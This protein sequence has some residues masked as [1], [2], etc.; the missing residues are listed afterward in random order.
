M[1]A[2]GFLID[3]ETR[4]VTEVPVKGNYQAIYPIIDASTFT[5]A[6][7]I[8][9]DEYSTDGIYLDDNG[10]FSTG[11]RVWYTTLYPEPLIGKGLV[12]GTDDEGESVSPAIDIETVRASIRWHQKGRVLVTTGG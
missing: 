3:P 7:V 11:K 5:V 9:D 1:N 2:T 10:M 12:M 6:P 8:V 4:T